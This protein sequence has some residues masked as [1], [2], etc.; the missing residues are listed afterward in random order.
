MKIAITTYLP[1]QFFILNLDNLDTESL[2]KNGLGIT[3]IVQIG[4]EKIGWRTMTVVLK[5][6]FCS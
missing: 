6:K 1:N 2:L 5:P 3:A 4:T